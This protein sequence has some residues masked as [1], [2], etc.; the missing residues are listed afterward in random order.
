MLR[1]RLRTILRLKS[2]FWESAALLDCPNSQL[3]LIW[4]G[5]CF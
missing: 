1:F 4:S 2:I 3:T 5:I